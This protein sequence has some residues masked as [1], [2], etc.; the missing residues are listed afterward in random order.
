MT[1]AIVVM[2][3]GQDSVTFLFWALKQWKDVEAVTFDFSQR[4]KVEVSQAETICKEVEVPWTLI[5]L[6]GFEAIKQSSALLSDKEIKVDTD[7]GLPTT[8]VPGRNM[9]FLTYAAALAYTKGCTNLVTGVTSADFWTYKNITWDWLAGFFEAEGYVSN[10]YYLNSKNEKVW[11]PTAGVCQNN[12]A[13]INKIKMF[14]DA[15]LGI[16]SHITSSRTTNGISYALELKYIKN[17]ND[18]LI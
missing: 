6:S 8:F 10:T 1:D 9:V 11:I 5:K 3:G 15:E 17:W 12:Y 18:V 7:T 4:H 16:T 2:S 14:V 13:I